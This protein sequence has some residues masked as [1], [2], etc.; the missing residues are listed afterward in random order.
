[1]PITSADPVA[2]VT[3]GA[4]GI[5]FACARRFAR[6]GMRVVIADIDETSGLA[7]CEEI[8]AHGGE[9]LFVHCDVGERF[10]IHNVMAETVDTFGRVDVMVAAAAAGA[11]S[12][13][14]DIDEKSFDAVMRVNLRGAFLAGQAVA[15]Q[16]VRQLQA[17]TSR[18]AERERPYSLIFISSVN[19]VM[20]S[21]TELAFAVSKGAVNQLA[22]SMAIALA[23]HGIRVNAI[24]PGTVSTESV[25]PL[26]SDAKTRANVL[27][28]TPLGRI[29]D[30]NEIAAIAAFLASREASYITG[31]CIYADGGRLALNYT[32]ETL[33]GGP[34]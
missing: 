8:E 12:A 17:T 7:A 14:L 27:S 33:A 31:Q 21:A 22:K 1:M 24:G 16:M 19:A 32:V 5:G 34:A 26:I 11:P 15:R 9:A 18:D 29:G 4:R 28:R 25:K 30:A 20:A 3:G 13:F 23:P 6:D 10:D 2:V